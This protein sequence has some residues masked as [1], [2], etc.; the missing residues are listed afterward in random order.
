MNTPKTSIPGLFFRTTSTGNKSTT[1]LYLIHYAS[2]EVV[3]K[4]IGIRAPFKLATQ[5]EKI[6][7]EFP[8][9]WT[10]S[11]DD[12]QADYIIYRPAVFELEKLGVSTE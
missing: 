8:L 7:R 6:L 3:A 4:F 11:A 10:L 12:I 5:I 2:S 1:N 9:D